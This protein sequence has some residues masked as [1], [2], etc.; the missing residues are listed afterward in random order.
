MKLK[1]TLKIFGIVVFFLILSWKIN[2]K[3]AFAED[4]SNAVDIRVNTPIGD[5]VSEGYDYQKNYYKFT[6]SQPGTVTIKFHNPL[7]K[8]SEQYWSVYLYNTEYE[9][10]FDMNIYGNK[11]STDS[12]A[13]GISVGTY[14]IQVSSE[15]WGEAKSTDVYTIEAD[16]SASDIW[17]KEL[18]EDFTSAT[19]MEVNKEYSGTTRKG[20]DYEKDYYKFQLAEPGA[21]TVEFSNP[22]QSDSEHYWNVYLYNS[23]Y[24]E[25]CSASV[26]GNKPNTNLVTTGLGS[27]TYYVKVNSE[28]WKE[29]DSTDVYTIKARFEPSNVWEKER[30]EDF[31]SATN[32]EIG[33]K[34][35][36]TTWAGYD[37]EK[38]FYKINLL[39]SNLYAVGL[40]TP[41][42]KDDNEY[43]KLYLYN[44][45][46]KEIA[47]KSVY[48]NK[49]YHSIS[50]YLS[51][52]TY[53]IKVESSSWDRA[54]S[55]EQYMLKVSP[56][57]TAGVQDACEHDYRSYDVDATYFNSGYTV[58]TCEKCGYSY[59]DDYTPKRVLSQGYL[60]YYCSSGKGKLY[61]AW[62]SVWNATGYQIRCSTD[63]GFKSGVI[64]K[65]VRGQSNLKKT[66]G[67]LYRKKKYYVQVRA[68]VKSGSKTAY[69]KWSEKKM[70]KTK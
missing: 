30:N 29:A 70:L 14:Y 60:S 40:T 39:K 13:C 31:T 57:D 32:I 66:I 37:Y 67:K 46:Y 2:V 23:Q 15:S 45:A 49:T 50:Q 9:Q 18:N 24:E 51:S 25:V 12:V 56:T 19:A 42:L 48:G 61:L 1:R 58:Y 52:G 54:L 20:Y 22:L 38:D 41:N 26:Y 27:G 53:Y 47:S 69:G 64:T 62:S 44:D 68:Y 59:K 63:K 35:S 5:S 3:T 28:S 10:L 16:F 8:D 55:T 36:G 4:F 17:E 33:T 21:V 11:T 43:W 7:Q 34:Y 65:N 6:V